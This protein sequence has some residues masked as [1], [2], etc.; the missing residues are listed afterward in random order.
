[1]T[2]PR[3]RGTMLPIRYGDHELVSG[4]YDGWDC[5]SCGNIIDAA[6]LQNRITPAPMVKTIENAEHRPIVVGRR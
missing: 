3:C 6:I 4:I 2:C 1:M 5:I